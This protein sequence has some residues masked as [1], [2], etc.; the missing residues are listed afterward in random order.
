MSEPAYLKTH[1]YE[2]VGRIEA[3]AT[4][5]V[6]YAEDTY[7]VRARDGGKVEPGLA[8][9]LTVQPGANEGRLRF[10]NYVGL[11]ELDGRLVRVDSARISVPNAE[12]MLDEL[13]A[14][15]GS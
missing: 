3:D 4:P 7:V 8:G 13:S 5:P 14:G 6:I 2:I 1:R 11:A 12:R 10:G 9:V 15:L